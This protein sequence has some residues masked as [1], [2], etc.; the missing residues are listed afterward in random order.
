MHQSSHTIVYTKSISHISPYTG[1]CAPIQ[2]DSG[3]QSA[4]IQKDS[5][6]QRFLRINVLKISGIKTT[7]SQQNMATTEKRLHLHLTYCHNTN[8]QTHSLWYCSFST[9]PATFAT[10]GVCLV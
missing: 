1:I 10:S 8:L 6:G 2:K 4:P 3:G 7:W 9:V 5:G